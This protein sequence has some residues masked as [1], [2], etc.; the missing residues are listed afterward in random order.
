[1][2]VVTIDFYDMASGFRT[3]KRWDADF[4]AVEGAGPRGLLAWVAFAGA[5]GMKLAVPEWGISS[6]DPGGGGDNAFFI[7][8]MYGFF[9]A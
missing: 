4:G 8:K 9:W 3:P 5:H 7:G 2:D 1:V 6:L